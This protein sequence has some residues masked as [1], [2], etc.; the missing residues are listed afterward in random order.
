MEPFALFN[1]TQ[2]YDEAQTLIKAAEAVCN[3]EIEAAYIASDTRGI[4]VSAS[5]DMAQA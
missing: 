2:E 1:K 5:G 4:N 3:D